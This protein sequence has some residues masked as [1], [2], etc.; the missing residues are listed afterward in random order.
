MIKINLNRFFFFLML[1]FLFNTSFAK[2]SDW[3]FLI[4]DRLQKN[5]RIHYI[6]R[7]DI[8]FAYFLKKSLRSKGKKDFSTV[9][10]RVKKRIFWKLDK[11]KKNVFVDAYQRSYPSVKRYK[12]PAKIPAF[13][14]LIPYI[15][16][17]WRAKAG[18]PSKDYGYW[19]LIPS[20]VKEIKKLPTT[21][22]YLKKKSINT[23]RSKHKLSTAIALIHLQRYY[24]Y[25]HS[26][27]KFNKTDAWLFSILSYNWGVGNVKRMLIKMK[28]KKITLN[29]SN[30][31][32]YL[33]QRYK[34][35]K[36]TRSLRSAVEY[37]PH[38]WNILQVIRQ[39]Y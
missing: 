35:K 8:L 3:D 24:F 19:Q 29:F 18:N 1:C 27:A 21:P 14:L 34:H 12:L 20:I 9:V 32:H 37:L 33:Y 11:N 36:T 5:T 38:L 31:Y 15:E 28:K 10:K 4:P 39:Q 22:A 6:E 17:L 26:M 7:L 13:I 23:L 25:F 16:S 2:S 30:F